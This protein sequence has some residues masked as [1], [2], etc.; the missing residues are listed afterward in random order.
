M[1]SPQY[2]YTVRRQVGVA[3]HQSKPLDASLCDQQTV[4]R[5]PMMERKR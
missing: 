3:R 5:I 1:T 2:R 4:K